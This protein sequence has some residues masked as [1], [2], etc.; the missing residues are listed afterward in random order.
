MQMIGKAHL[1]TDQKGAPPLRRLLPRSSLRSSGKAPRSPQLEGSV[2]FRLL[3]FKERLL[4]AG[5]LP[6]LAHDSG[7]RPDS[8]F[9]R[10][11]KCLSVTNVPF[12][13]HCCGRL[14]FRLLL[15]KDRRSSHIMP[16]PTEPQSSGSVPCSL[17]SSISRT[18]NDGSAPEYAQVSGSMPSKLL[19][20]RSRSCGASHPILK[21][22]SICSSADPSEVVAVHHTTHSSMHWR[23]E[24]LKQRT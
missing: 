20:P 5:K 24:I 23:V 19:R 7:S 15:V 21:H 3:L 11:C 13:P 1:L 6:Y 17:F 22:A 10:R 12:A 4:S 14:P 2:P 8:L 9:C 18:R 16:P